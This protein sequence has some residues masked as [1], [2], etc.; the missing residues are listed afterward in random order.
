[1]LKDRDLLKWAL[2][3]ALKSIK[4]KNTRVIFLEMSNVQHAE[5]LTNKGIESEIK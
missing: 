3:Q 5:F 1:M 4:S 2:G